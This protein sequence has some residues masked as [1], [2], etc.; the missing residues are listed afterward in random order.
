[1]A[2]LEVEDYVGI[3]ASEKMAFSTRNGREQG[4]GVYF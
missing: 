2:L 1:M 4:E 3:D